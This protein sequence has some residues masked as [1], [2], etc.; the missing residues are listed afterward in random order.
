M[1]SPMTTLSNENLIVKCSHK[2]RVCVCLFKRRSPKQDLKKTNLVGLIEAN[3]S[4]Q[5]SHNFA[6]FTKMATL[7]RK[8][9]NEDDT[10]SPPPYINLVLSDDDNGDNQPDACIHPH[11]QDYPRILRAQDEVRAK[12]GY[13]WLATDRSRESNALKCTYDRPVPSRGNCVMCGRSGPLGQFC[14]NGCKYDCVSTDNIRGMDSPPERSAEYDSDGD[15]HIQPSERVQYRMI[16]TPK[17]NNVI[18]AVYFAELMYK[19]VDKEEETFSAWD[20]K[21]ERFKRRKHDKIPS[22]EQ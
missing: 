17:N 5:S 22:N 10:D 8:R 7:K 14:S 19:G 2:R 11:G 13:V 6:T 18:D 12:N 9:A 20:K 3:L 4:P 16:K 1:T 21:T 15:L